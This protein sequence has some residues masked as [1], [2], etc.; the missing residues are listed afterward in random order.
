[1][2]L[3]TRT[4]HS[5]SAGERQPAHVLQRMGSN[6]ALMRREIIFGTG[7]ALAMLLVAV[8]APAQSLVEIAQRERARRAAIAPEDRARV[9]TNDDLRDSG[10][11]TIGALPT[12]A[13]AEL[14]AGSGWAAHGVGGNGGTT[15]PDAGEVLDE[16]DWRSRMTSAQEERARAEL[17]AAALQNRA[18]GLWAQ[19]TA[20]DDPARRSVVERQRTEAL[21]ELER[22]RA[23]AERLDQHIR[24]IQE[25][26]RRA[27][28][29]PGWL[30]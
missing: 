4:I 13:A 10:G 6:G 20:I 27:G 21:E 29:P 7:A 14:D 15:A 25:E 3:S 1:M 18:D 9:Y 26:A 19:F 17:M 30:R 8:N 2:R 16:D 22:T 23:E 5:C 12:V 11:L 28:V 24:D